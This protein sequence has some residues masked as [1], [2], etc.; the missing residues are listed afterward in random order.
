MQRGLIFNQHDVALVFCNGVV[1][2]A[3]WNNKNIAFREFNRSILHL[4]LQLTFE[5]QKQFILILMAVPCQ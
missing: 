1:A 3:F 5:N 2:N 4:D